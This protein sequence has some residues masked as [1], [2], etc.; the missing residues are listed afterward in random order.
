MRQFF[1]YYSYSKD[2][3]DLEDIL[4]SFGNYINSFKYILEAIIAVTVIKKSL[5][6]FF[7]AN[8]AHIKC[9]LVLQPSFKKVTIHISAILEISIIV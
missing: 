9:K 8:N 3:V 1:L 6:L 5:K 4:P 2:L 7:K